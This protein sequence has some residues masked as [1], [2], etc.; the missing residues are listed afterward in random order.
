MWDKMHFV[1][2]LAPNTIDIALPESSM[3]DCFFHRQRK[4]QQETLLEIILYLTGPYT[5]NDCARNNYG[6]K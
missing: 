2:D 5:V 4:M 3:Y 1:L 6:S